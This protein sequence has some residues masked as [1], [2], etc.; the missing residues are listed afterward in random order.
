[1]LSHAFCM[2]V[3]SASINPPAAWGLD[4]VW[5][6]Y[7]RASVS[8]LQAAVKK[9]I[10]RKRV[11]PQGS[12]AEV[13]VF[14]AGRV[15][16]KVRLLG[17]VVS[18]KDS[19]WARE[20]VLDDGTGLMPCIIFRNDS[21]KNANLAPFL[22]PEVKLLGLLLHVGGPVDIFSGKPQLKVFFASKE[23]NVNAEILFW[24]DTLDLHH[25]VYS[26]PFAPLVSN[27]ANCPSLCHP[28]LSALSVFPSLPPSLPLYFPLSV[29][30]SRSEKGAQ[31]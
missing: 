30:P 26:A 31:F 19:G 20:F 2:D 28:T 6:A 25:N 11:G 15:V 24:M 1:V 29:P 16:R 22:D 5:D 10:V 27:P 4:P 9:S 3:L 13:L 14:G 23:Q 21:M 17:Y 8:L 7:A 18:V 12:Q